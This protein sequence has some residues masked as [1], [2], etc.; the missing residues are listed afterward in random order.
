MAGFSAKFYLFVETLRTG[1]WAVYPLLFAAFASIIAVYYYFKI[2]YYMF[3]KP[4]DLKAFK[5]NAAFNKTNIC[6]FILFIS[7]SLLFILFFFGAPLIEM[8]NNIV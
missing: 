1:V 6:T 5:K 4:T 7:A 2:I 8:L 3:L